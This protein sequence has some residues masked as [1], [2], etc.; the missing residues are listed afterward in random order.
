MQ[1]FKY[2]A[3]CSRRAGM[4]FQYFT[5][6][7]STHT[8]AITRHAYT[9]THTTARDSDVNLAD[10]AVVTMYQSQSPYQVP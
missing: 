9:H 2:E 10:L 6:W 4:I 3:G 7:I 5:L 8:Q 1:G